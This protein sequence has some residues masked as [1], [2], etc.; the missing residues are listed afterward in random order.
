MLRSTELNTFGMT[1]AIYRDLVCRANGSNLSIEGVAFRG[2]N[3]TKH[4][5]EYTTVT[6]LYC[7]W[8]SRLLMQRLSHIIATESHPLNR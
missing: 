7:R 6:R 1:N 4:L 3:M 2:D 8:Y 5:H